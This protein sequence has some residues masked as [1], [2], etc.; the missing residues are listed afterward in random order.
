MEIGNPNNNPAVPH[1]DKLLLF[2]WTIGNQEC[3][4]TIRDQHAESWK[5]RVEKVKGGKFLLGIF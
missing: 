2:L 1:N 3:F 4:R 5:R